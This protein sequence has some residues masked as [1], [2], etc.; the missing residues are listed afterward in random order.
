MF[1]KASRVSEQAG[2][3][4]GGL[5][6]R[7]L[8]GKKCPLS[9]RSGHHEQPV[10]ASVPIEHKWIYEMNSFLTWICLSSLV[11]LSGCE[12]P[13][14]FAPLEKIVRAH[15]IDDS[16]VA[17]IYMYRRTRDYQVVMLKNL[18]LCSDQRFKY[19][20]VSTFDKET[21]KVFLSLLSNDFERCNIIFYGTAEAVNEA[22]P[23]FLDGVF[24]SGS[25]DANSNV[26]LV[27]DAA[28]AQFND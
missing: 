8:V 11:L 14:E 20:A 13:D 3:G 26:K 12:M 9:A 5:Y 25:L 24:E 4:G 17:Y 7:A 6:F 1:Y 10:L 15:G 22:R 2:A 16:E 27:Y 18:K 19:L 23:Y 28:A 21:E